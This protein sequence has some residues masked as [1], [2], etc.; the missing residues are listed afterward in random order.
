MLRVVCLRTGTK[1]GPEYVTILNDMIRRN[2]E[3]RTPGTFEC[4]TDQPERYE[5]IFVR[6]SA[7]HG[8]WWD[9]LAFMQ[10]GMWDPGDRIWYFDLDTCI[11]GPLDGILKYEGPFA[12][13]IDFYNQKFLQA[14]CMTWVQ[15]EMDHIYPSWISQGMPRLE[16]G[17]QEFI[18][19]QHPDFNKLQQLFPRRFVSYKI[20]ASLLLPDDASV[21][22]FHGDPKP[23][24]IKAGWVPSVWQ[25]NAE[26]GA[27][28][29]CVGNTHWMVVRHNIALN[30]QLNKNWI[31]EARQPY[32]GENQD[33][34]FVGGGPSAEG[35]LPV[36]RHFSKKMAVFALNNSANWCA[37]N[38][39][40]VD[41]QVIMDARPEM[42]SM[43]YYP[44]LKVFASQCDP[45]V[46]KQADTL[47]HAY[48]DG[49]PTL[50]PDGE[51]ARSDLM[52]GGGST[53]GLVAMS[54]AH[55][56]GFRNFHLFG[57]D[58]CYQGDRHHSYP[59]E[60]NDGEPIVI[61]NVGKREFRCAPWMTQQAREF[62]IFV[63]MLNMS[64]CEITAYG[65]GLLQC[66]IKEMA[67]KGV[68]H[69]KDRG[70]A[71]L[72]RVNGATLGAEIGVSLGRLS[73][74]L[75]RENQNLSMYLVD[76]Y[77]EYCDSGFY[78][79]QTN[80]D[81]RSD[82]ASNSMIQFGERAKWLR[83]RSLDAAKLVPDG[84][85]DFVFIDADHSY[86]A[87]K[88][89]ILAWRPKLKAGGLLCG[90]DYHNE[91]N[92]FPGVDRAV[93]ELV[94]SVEVGPNFTWF[95]S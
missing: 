79:S 5:G 73:S 91:E 24:T 7:G 71:I 48:A 76:P 77:F 38:G 28:Q 66:L 88:A 82:Y 62:Q 69:S 89:D 14:S 9:K 13:L 54:V 20:D 49:F 27:A 25:V 41:F 37:E 94:P 2:L 64:G 92:P 67:E 3:A 40:R 85:L 21:V 56:L 68:G 87:C 60:L 83:M 4:F 16:N 17:D 30:C 22:D 43:I 95:A 39:V 15:G 93:D 78:V 80:Q 75:L 63:P 81:T 6:P 35:M 59:Q 45:S 12:G 65:D 61:G 84:T 47:F 90:H 31:R 11:V 70:D 10:A 74:Y 52:L 86:E 34:I 23:H 50:L 19:N 42:A 1:Y 57:Y 18:F 51:D 46:A 55:S 72:S 26:P 44:A 8:S 33:C 29:I 32:S 58:S 36:I 53:V